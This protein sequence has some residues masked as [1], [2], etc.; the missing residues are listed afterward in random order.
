L[1]VWTAQGTNWASEVHWQREI[2]YF[3]LLLS[4]LFLWV[5]AQQNM[6]FKVAACAA[7]ASLSLVLGLN[8][9]EGWL[10]APRV[11]HVVFTM[12]NSVAMVWGLGAIFYARKCAP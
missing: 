10:A 6:A 3:D 11:F 5:A 9:L 2:A 8:H 7:I 4:A 12:G 1:P